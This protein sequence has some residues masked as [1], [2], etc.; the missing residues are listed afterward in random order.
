MNRPPVAKDDAYTTTRNRAFFIAA[1]GVLANDTDAD[2]DPT[3]AALATKPAHGTLT[4]NANGSFSY[5]PNA[6]FLGADS[7]TYAPVDHFDAVGTAATVNITVAIKAVTQAVNGGDTVNTG[8]DAT[9]TDPLVSSVMSPS[10][11]TVQIAQG[12]ISASQPPTGYTFLN[13]QI[14]ITILNQDGRDA[15][16]HRKSKKRHRQFSRRGHGKAGP[17]QL[18]EPEREQQP[19]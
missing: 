14:T 12:V 17:L 3:T 8:V 10:A 7:F 11:A 1:P 13:Q 2:G 18:L 15:S 19:A 16:S 5:V 4:L 9:P 6:D